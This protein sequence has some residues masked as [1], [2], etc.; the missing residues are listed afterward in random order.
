ML[1]IENETKNSTMRRFHFDKKPFEKSEDER[2]I[3][4]GITY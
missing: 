2:D 3:L 1:S 4:K